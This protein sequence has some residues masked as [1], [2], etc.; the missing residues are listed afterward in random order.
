LKRVLV[1]IGLVACT[2]I[3]TPTTTV[4]L[5]PSSTVT[6]STVT[7]GTAPPEPTASTVPVTSGETSPEPATVVTIVPPLVT[8]VATT[9]ATSPPLVTSP[10]ITLTP[11]LAVVF[12]APAEQLLIASTNLVR[13]SVGLPALID[14]NDL[15]FYARVWAGHLSKIGELGHSDIAT[16]LG[17]WL[18]VGENI[19]AG[20]DMGQIA[21]AL[22]N[23]SDHYQTMVE[24]AYLYTGVGVAVDSAGKLWVCQVFGGT[25]LP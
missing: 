11:E 22:A 5:I 15:D 14:H 4:E 16:L 6:A 1:L 21:Q 23:S 8:A 24:P 18:I 7:Q 2:A 3:A 9:L 13:T 20:T 19:A 12:S 10:P 17:P 25:I